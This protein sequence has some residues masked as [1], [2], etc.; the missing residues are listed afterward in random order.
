M[1]LARTTDI[2][3]FVFGG[4]TDLKI[5]SDRRRVCS[6]SN[7]GGPHSYYVHDLEQFLDFPKSQF[8]DKKAETTTTNSCLLKEKYAMYL[9]QRWRDLLSLPN[10][11]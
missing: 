9:T 10:C 2:S 6:E 3:L 4:N 8:L 11:H 1:F 7:A 5:A